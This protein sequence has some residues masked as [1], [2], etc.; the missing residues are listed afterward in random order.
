M[1]QYSLLLFTTVLQLAMSGTHDAPFMIDEDN[2]TIQQPKLQ[3]SFQKLRCIP[4]KTKTV[5]MKADNGTALCLP[6]SS[7]GKHGTTMF[8][9]E[10]NYGEELTVEDGMVRFFITSRGVSI[11]SNSK[12]EKMNSVNS[13]YKRSFTRSNFKRKISEKAKRHERIRIEPKDVPIL[14]TPVLCDLK[15]LLAVG[16]KEKEVELVLSMND[17]N[18]SE[19]GFYVDLTFFENKIF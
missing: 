5:E 14:S 12:Y 13:I 9:L 15:S 1:R 3:I 17:G 18:S 7:I 4:S 8:F 11:R 2:N 19:R 10:F 16:R 6:L